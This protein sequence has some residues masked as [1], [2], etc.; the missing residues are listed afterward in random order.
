MRWSRVGWGT[1]I[2]STLH[3]LAGCTFT[4]DRSAMVPATYKIKER[5]QGVVIIQVSGGEEASRQ[6][7]GSTPWSI[8]DKVFAEAVEDAI[9]QSGLFT[10]VVSR[11]EADFRIQVVLQRLLLPSGGGEMESQLSA[12]WVLRA[13]TPDEVLWQDFLVTTG[14]TPAFETLSGATRITRS[15]ERAANKNIL[16]AIQE[17]SLESLPARERLTQTG[18]MSTETATRV[19]GGRAELTDGQRAIA[20]QLIGT[21]QGSINLRRRQ[22]DVNRRTLVISSVRREGDKLVALGDY[23]ITGRESSPVTINVDEEEGA[24]RLSFTTGEGS[25]IS[26]ALRGNSLTGS[27]V[28]RTSEVRKIQLDRVE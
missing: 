9:K 12:L 28:R 18:A 23:A 14:L 21:W 15:M 11:G 10:R 20:R 8:S 26:L 3:V 6:V 13:G 24:P 19:E 2:V 5:Y 25:Q 4:P 16:R 22:R 17:M 27:F 1:L 7:G